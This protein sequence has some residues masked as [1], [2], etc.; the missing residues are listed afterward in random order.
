MADGNSSGANERICE[1]GPYFCKRDRNKPGTISIYTCKGRQT[2][3]VGKTGECSPKGEVISEAQLGRIELA[4][5]RFVVGDMEATARVRA[6]ITKS[7]MFVKEC[8]SQQVLVRQAFH[9]GAVKKVQDALDALMQSGDALPEQAMNLRFQ[10]KRATVAGTKEGSTWKSL[11]KLLGRV[12]PEGDGPTVSQFTETKQL[13]F[14]TG[15]MRIGYKQTTVAMFLSCLFSAFNHCD[16]AE[17]LLL[18]VPRRMRQEAWV[19]KNDEDDEVVAYEL[20]D[21]AA[22]FNAASKNESWWRYMNLATHGARPSTLTEATWMQILSMEP[23]TARWRLNPPGKR[24]TKKRRPTI[25][26]CHTLACELR[27]WERNCYRIVSDASGKPVANASS[28]FDAIKERAGIKHGSAKSMRSGIRTWLMVQG[29]P[30]AI[31]DLFIGHADEGSAT[32]RIFYKGKKPKYMAE[33]AA[34]IEKLYDALRPLVHR[35]FA[36]AVTLVEQPTPA[37][38]EAFWPSVRGKCVAL[39]AVTG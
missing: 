34:A 36:G 27:S 37:E 39:H 8:V 38:W 5:A 19:I 3:P 11:V 31:A 24:R 22:L 4:L 15:A 20:E 14:A 10:V 28:L 26:I 7:D 9:A 33:A 32:G 30:D 16:R 18:K 1:S 25:P 17:L 2:V 23:G 21:I 35:S 13:E 12:W 6:G 29:V